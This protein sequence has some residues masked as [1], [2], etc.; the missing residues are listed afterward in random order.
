M[1]SL[2]RLATS[3]ALWRSARTVVVAGEASKAL[4]GGVRLST[5]HVSPSSLDAPLLLRLRQSSSFHASASGRDNA[6]P[7]PLNRRSVWGEASA[8]CRSTR[9]GFYD[10][11]VE[12][13]SFE[14]LESALYSCSSKKKKKSSFSL[15]LRPRPP[16]PLFFSSF[17]VRS[18]RL[19]PN[20]VALE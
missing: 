12:Q 16:L 19:S 8:D 9:E 18:R 2:T 5:P 17:S 6:F 7:F 14:R 4:E 13:V 10:A 3:H 15:F 1:R 20:F 11:T